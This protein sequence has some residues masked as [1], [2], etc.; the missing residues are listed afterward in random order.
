MGQ[1]D[2]GT[3]RANV[4]EGKL[5]KRREQQIYRAVVHGTSRALYHQ[6]SLHIDMNQN[7]E[8]Q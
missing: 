3:E 5:G 2:E 8:T 7:F 1:G 6:V 4:R